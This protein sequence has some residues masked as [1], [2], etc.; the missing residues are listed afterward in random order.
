[1]QQQPPVKL[2][3]ADCP[4]CKG[5]WCVRVAT[6]R[7]QEHTRRALHGEEVIDWVKIYPLAPIPQTPCEGSH[8]FVPESERYVIGYA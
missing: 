3:T 7:L 8:R 4:V 1:M 2:E 5:H 6:G